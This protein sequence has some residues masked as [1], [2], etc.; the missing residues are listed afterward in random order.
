MMSLT[1]VGR[2]RQQLRL[3]FLLTLPAARVFQNQLIKRSRAD[4]TVSI[5]LDATFAKRSCMECGG[6]P[7]RRFELVLLGR[8]R[9]G[10]AKNLRERPRRMSARFGFSALRRDY[11]C[12]GCRSVT[13][14]IQNQLIKRSRTD[15]TLSIRLDATF[16]KQIREKCGGM[17][18]RHSASC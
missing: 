7:C 3:S 18:C 4:D 17:P 2:H 14:L 1:A 12:G 13:N 6:V 15:H 16:A 5:R 10:G 11:S 8:G 9:S